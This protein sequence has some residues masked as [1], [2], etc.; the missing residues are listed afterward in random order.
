MA[1]AVAD[2]NSGSNQGGFT[3]DGSPVTGFSSLHDSGTGGS[4]S[5]GN[6]PLFPYSSCSNDDPDSCNYLKSQRTVGFQNTSVVATP[7]YFALTLD[8]GVAVDMTTAEH[9]SLFRFN[10]T[11]SSSTGSPLVLLD[12][13]DLS[14]SRQDNATIQVD[15]S[16]SRM[17]GNSVFKP[18]FGSGNYTAYF[19]ADFSGADVRDNGIFVN[20]RANSTVKTL[21]VSRGINGIPL[22]AGA[23]TRFAA[24]SSSVLARVGLS[25]I[26]TDRACSNAE[27]EISDY[28]FDSTRQA[29]TSAWETKLSPIQIELSS[30]DPSYVTN[31]Y[32]GIYRTMQ[33]PQNYTNENPLFSSP[34]YFDSYYCL[35]DSFR[36]QF[37]FLT[38]LDPNAVTQMVQSLIS[39]YQ[40][41]G[42]LP[43][44]RMS[45]CKGYTQGGSNA[46]NIIGDAF[47]KNLTGGIDYTMGYAAVVNDAENEPYDW[48]N[49]GRGGLDSWK[50]LGYIPVLDFDYK[51]FGTFTRS[52]SRTLE[53]AYNDF[54]IAQIATGQGNTDDA[55]KYNARAEN[56][57]NLFKADQTSDLLNS[58]TSTGF[59]GFFQPKYLNGTWGFQ[60]PLICSDIDNSGTAC[61]LTNNGQ[62]TFESS[63]WEYSFYVPQDQAALITTFGGADQFVARLNY[64][65]D[66]NIT[67][68]GNE[69]AFLT[70]FQY[71]YAG[72]PALS[73]LRSHFYIPGFFGTTP[74][75]L[76]G[77]DDSGAMG[78]FVAFSM[79][80]L[81]P[82]PGQNVY[83]ITPPYFESINVT[84]PLTGNTATVRNVGFDPTYQNVY[85]QNAT[86][87]GQVYTKNWLDHSFFLDGG[88][89]VLY[90]G[91]SESAWGTGA[92]NVPPSLSASPLGPPGVPNGNATN[93]TIARRSLIYKPQLGM[94][95]KASLDGNY[96]IE[97]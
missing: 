45:L 95:G 86:L 72:R 91:S 47:V 75:G 85:I 90:L 13:T 3:L 9:T 58:T 23:W 18:S 66:N 89:L 73:A 37:P 10:F 25:Y 30:V 60:D 97:F 27:T 62:E 56:W 42:W 26:S 41:S 88:E 46:D 53:Y 61:S 43:D 50:A 29:A 33:S 87:N 68:I 5:L 77:N 70:V 48:S 19:C 81:F 34:Y 54:V 44:C 28:D 69:P 83:L 36:S 63:I 67:Y 64:L 59:V 38:V 11:N 14:D 79:I 22:P 4:P 8:S 82:V 32:S 55:A 7:G 78:S 49:E 20:S 94:D 71:H 80:G 21:Q 92:I 2:T 57:K 65:H 51:G 96:G 93:S 35:W 15:G 17:T 16:T 39:I 6:F 74:D 40:A 1:K 76:P 12:L 24:G 52:V 84:S 31:F